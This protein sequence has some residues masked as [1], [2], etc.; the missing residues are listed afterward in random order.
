MAASYLKRPPERPPETLREWWHDLDYQAGSWESP[1]RVVL[2]MQEKTDDLLPH[3]F[4]LVTNFSR[5]HYPPEKVLAL[6]RKR[7]KA[8]AHMVGLKS[9]LD[10]HLSSADPGHLTVQDVMTRNQVCRQRQLRPSRCCQT[11]RP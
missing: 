8:E 2:I 5:Y 9:A 3:A 6:Y 7:G 4:F 11:R 1:R 10:L